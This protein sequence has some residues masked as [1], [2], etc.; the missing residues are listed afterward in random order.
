MKC[1]FALVLMATSITGSAHTERVYECKAQLGS[2]IGNVFW[3]SKEVQAFELSFLE[4]NDRNVT[5]LP[6]LNL[7]LETSFSWSG[8]DM[9]LS[10]PTQLLGALH[11]WNKPGT[12]P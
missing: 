4:E 10:T 5:K 3:V 11:V 2:F 9:T 8:V 12:H 6:D 7:E 1:F